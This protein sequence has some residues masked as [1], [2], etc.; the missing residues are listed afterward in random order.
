MGKTTDLERFSDIML[1]E[2][3]R[4]QDRFDAIDTRFDALENKITGIASEIADIHRRLDTLE[5]AIVNVS[6]FTKEIDHLLQ[7]VSAIERHLGLA[8]NIK[9]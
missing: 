3:K 8:I 5:E 9:A 4:M 1:D 2:F 7:R 6:G